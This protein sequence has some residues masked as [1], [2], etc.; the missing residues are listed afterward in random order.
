MNKNEIISVAAMDYN[1][2][3]YAVC[4]HEGFVVFVKD[5]M[6]GEVAEVRLEKVSERHAYARIVTMVNA[7]KDRV[8]PRCPIAYKCGGCQIQHMNAQAQL[9]FKK[10]HVQSLFKR[11]LAMDINPKIHGMEDPWFYRNKT[12]V[13]FEITKR[14]IDYG[15]YRAH[16]HD[17]L[18]FS[19]CYIQSDDSNSILLDIKRFYDA[20]AIKPT[21]LRTVLV[22]KAFST[23]ELMVVFVCRR[24]SLP[25]QKQL[26]EELQ[27]KHPMIKS[28]VINV[29]DREDNVILGD[30]YIPLTTQ[31]VITDTL[32]GLKFEISAASFFQVNPKQA[33]ILYESAL[34][35]AKLKATDTVLDLYCGIGTIALLAAQ[36]AKAVIGVE[37]VQDAIEDAKRNATLNGVNN[38]EWIKTDAG[39]AVK[40]LIE[41]KRK[42]NLVV[43]DP[44]RKG[45]DETTRNA[46]I[47]LKA[48]KVIYV[49]CDPGTL[50]R[51]LKILQEH[52]KIE[53]VELTDMFPQTIHVETV[54]LLTRI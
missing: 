34:K 15:F 18:P 16:T 5:L 13:P 32:S 24:D 39:V 7:S 51:D 44:P 48:P 42:I 38:V 41:S 20:N 40:G 17:I 43:V 37:V 4:K 3:A 12:Q 1:E 36:K 23:G 33:E 50:V 26:V 52:Y 45:L 11:N 31:S 30:R 21:G 2:Q 46:I 22:K 27:A 8:E 10:M 29:N 19:T 47:E 35:M 25:S 6:I 54:V 28:I 49:S 9:D 53:D 14:T